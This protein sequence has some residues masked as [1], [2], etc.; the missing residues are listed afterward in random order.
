[1]KLH[2]EGHSSMSQRRKL[3]S[4]L[5]ISKKGGGWSNFNFKRVCQ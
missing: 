4:M 1:M 2:L 5:F 3:Q